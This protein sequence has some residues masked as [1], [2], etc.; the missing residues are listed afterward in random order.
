[1]KPPSVSHRVP[2][3]CVQLLY[4]RD[5]DDDNDSADGGYMRLLFQSA[6]TRQLKQI[7]C[8]TFQRLKV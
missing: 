2:A 1:M 8:L 4:Q 6:Q 5:K 3:E 7:H